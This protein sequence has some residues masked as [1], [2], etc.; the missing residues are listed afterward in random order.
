[1]FGASKF[2]VPTVESKALLSLSELRFRRDARDRRHLD[3]TYRSC[4]YA[5]FNDHEEG[6]SESAGTE[7]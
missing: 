1:M 3:V 4:S 6:V 7:R 5:V 2:Q